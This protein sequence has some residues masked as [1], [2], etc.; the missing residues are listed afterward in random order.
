MEI[1]CVL[2]PYL[3]LEYVP[4]GEVSGDAVHLK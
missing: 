3:G 4:L 1:L 2:D